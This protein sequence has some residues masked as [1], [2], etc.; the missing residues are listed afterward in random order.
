MSDVSDRPKAVIRVLTQTA[1][2]PTF[3]P[4]SGAR[5]NSVSMDDA[6]R[7]LCLDC[8]KN[9]FESS[10]DYYFLKDRLW[11]K[12]VPREQR[13]GMICRTC[14]ERRLGRQLTPEDFRRA[15]DDESDPED[16]PMRDEDYGIYDA[17]TPQM[18]QA[19]NSAIIEFVTS[20]PRRVTAIVRYMYE[21]APA[22]IPALHDWFYM[23]RIAELI[24]DG[25][26]AVVTEGEDL[27][28]HIVRAATSTSDSQN[29]R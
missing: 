13:H 1:A 21:D 16:Q 28:S 29:S 11:R 23:D 20:R 12:L 15:T 24:D 4:D 26:L 27:R 17:L 5:Y 25:A 19:I 2:K 14:I 22:P 8:G 10:E 9:T 7:W 6:R 18:H 3:G